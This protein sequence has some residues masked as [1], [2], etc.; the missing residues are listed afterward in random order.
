VL[1]CKE[2]RRRGGEVEQLTTCPQSCDRVC[3]V[4]LILKYEDEEYTVYSIARRRSTLSTTPL[5]L[6]IQYVAY[7]LSSFI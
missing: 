4:L 6:A 5:L 3:V 7:S 2:E 1:Y